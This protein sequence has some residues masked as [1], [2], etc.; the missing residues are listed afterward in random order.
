MIKDTDEH[1]D[2]DAQARYVGRVM[3]LPCPLQAYHSPSTSTGSATWKFSE[4]HTVGIS[5]EASSCKQD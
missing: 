4:S 1:S 5:M 2:G 3:E